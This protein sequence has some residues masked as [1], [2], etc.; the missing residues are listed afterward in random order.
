MYPM[1]HIHIVGDV[2]A[3]CMS[4]SLW[5]WYA[6]SCSFA[7]KSQGQFLY[8]FRFLFCLIHSL[9]KFILLR[10]YL[11]PFGEGMLG[12]MTS[13]FLLSASQVHLGNLEQQLTQLSELFH[14]VPMEG[15]RV[16]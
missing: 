15:K 16:P 8:I 3:R 1:G 6:A 13:V 14:T 12:N 4:A 2:A 5:K 7:E 9:C 10:P 11:E